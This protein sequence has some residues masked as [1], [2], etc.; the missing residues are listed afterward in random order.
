M[1][2]KNLYHSN[3]RDR[4][5]DCALA[6]G[7]LAIWIINGLYHRPE[8]QFLKLAKDACQH[9]PT[10]YDDYVD[11]LETEDPDVIMPLMYEAGLYFVCDIVTDDS[12]TFRLPFHKAISDDAFKNAFQLS[13]EDV[14]QVMGVANHNLSR[15][16][17][18]PDRTNNRSKRR[19]LRVQ[20]IRPPDRTLPEVNEA[21]LQNVYIRPTRSM[22]GPDV[23]HFARHGGGNRDAQVLLN[24]QPNN[25]Q[26]ISLKVQHILEQFFYDMLQES[27]NRKG[28]SQGAWTNIP[29]EL[30]VQEATEHLY[31][32]FGLPFFAAQFTFSTDEQWTLHFNRMF[33][34]QPPTIKAQNFGKCTYFL[35]WL[36]LIH[37]LSPQSTSRVRTT[38]RAK[39]NTLLWIPYTGSDRM[40]CTRPMKGRGWFALPKGQEPTGPQI[41]LNPNT[42]LYGPGTPF[43][44]PIPESLPEDPRRIETPASEAEEEIDFD[45]DANNDANRQG[46]EALRQEE[47]E[48]EDIHV[49]SS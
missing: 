9:I 7:A 35:K 26:D 23:D 37:S 46:V 30:R 22:G 15:R 32:T 4:K 49:V 12:G 3:V 28:A 45:M 43:L 39:F 16:V 6:L 48:E 33:P 10:D 36:E 21:L 42:H 8:D 13:I 25:N 27:P 38:I 17:I 24:N 29:S 44:R 40:W 14:R 41:A 5:S 47:E 20:D 11:G 2:I 18:N 19:T 34:A 31:Q 1:V